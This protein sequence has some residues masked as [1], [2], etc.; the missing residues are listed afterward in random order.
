MRNHHL[1]RLALA[2]LGNPNQQI[3]SN[4]SSTIKQNIIPKQSKVSPAVIKIDVDHLE[5]RIRVGHRTVVT[6]SSAASTFTFKIPTMLRNV[7]RE[8]IA[9]IRSVRGLKVQNLIRS[10]SYWCV[11]ESCTEESFNYIGEGVHS[12][13]EDPETREDVRSSEDTTK[14][15]HHDEEQV[16]NT[17]CGVGIGKTGDDHVR[18]C[19]SEEEEHQDV[20]ENGDAT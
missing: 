3:N 15:E 7:S 16:Q 11:R 5:E 9:T 18:E 17:S 19:R 20:E 4:S 13:H 14:G 8:K 1:R 2:L 12:V 6:L 10:T